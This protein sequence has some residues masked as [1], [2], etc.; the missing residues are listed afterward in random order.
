MSGKSLFVG[1]IVFQGL[2]MVKNRFGAAEDE[3]R[4]FGGVGVF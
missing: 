2:E 4:L 1:V 3:N